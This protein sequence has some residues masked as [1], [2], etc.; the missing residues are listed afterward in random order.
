MRSWFL[1]FASALAVCWVVAPAAA[2]EFAIPRGIGLGQAV[3]LSDLSASALLQFPSASISKGT[4]VLESGILR[5]FGLKD[6]DEALLVG[7]YRFGRFT[8]VGGFSQFG[9]SELYTE[10]TFK[11]A[12]ACKVGNVG[13]GVTWSHL[14]LSFGGSYSGL[15]V[16][17]IGASLSYRQRRVLLALAADN[18]TS[19]VLELGSPDIKP[20]YSVRAE[21]LG[22]GS[23][24][25]VTGATFEDKQ[26]PRFSIGQIVN[27]S[28]RA[29]LLWSLSSEPLV[30]AGGLEV[31]ISYGRVG[32]Y[33]S[34]HPI[35]GF[36]NCVS[37]SYRWGGEN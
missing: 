20:Q 7:G 17:T 11:F 8:A 4:G 36:T 21:L 19:P 5:R 9:R 29:S 2:L 12:A 31:N 33:T 30:Y 28:S 34:Y 32:Y 27:V 37:L 6:L 1:I 15:S 26:K 23:F 35:L 3:V 16:S 24:S 25:V 22:R 13:M 10:K 18:L 14:S